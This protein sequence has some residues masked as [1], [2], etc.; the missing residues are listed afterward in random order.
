[1]IARLLS[2]LRPA[3]PSS[4]GA[5]PAPA[6]CVI[7]DGDTAAAHASKAHRAGTKARIGHIHHLVEDR[8]VDL[9]E[10]DALASDAEQHW[11][12]FRARLAEERQAKA[13]AADLTPGDFTGG[14]RD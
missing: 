7:H 8:D 13:K 1:M 14:T 4:Q 6:P 3:A 9:D 10:L 11:R 5:A 2:L 12:T